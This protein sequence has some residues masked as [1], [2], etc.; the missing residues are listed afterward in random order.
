MVN[1]GW[2]FQEKFPF[3]YKAVSTTK[4]P[5]SCSFSPDTNCCGN[6]IKSKN[7][8]SVFGLDSMKNIKTLYPYCHTED[9]NK[10]YAEGIGK[11]IMSFGLRE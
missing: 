11:T 4:A 7:S 2:V 6:V 8:C 5:K 9:K 3:F 10:G 1:A